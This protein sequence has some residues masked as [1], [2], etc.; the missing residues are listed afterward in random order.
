LKKNKTVLENG[1]TIIGID[2]PGAKT[3]AIHIGFR[4]GSRTE[5]PEISGI[6]HFLEHMVFKGS[7]KRPTAA[8]IAKEV[9]R[10]G[11]QYNA[12]TGKE[13]TYYHIH[14]TPENFDLALDVV[15]D[16]ATQ[17]II[18]PK[19]FQKER[20]TIIE[21]IKMYEDNPSFS[22]F[23]KMEGTLFGP[24]TV[25]GRDIA[26]TEESVRGFTQ[27]QMIAYFKK[28]YVGNNCIAVVAGKLPDNYEENVSEYLEV[29][30]KGVRTNWEKPSYAEKKLDVIFKDTEQAHFGISFPAFSV[31]SQKRF[32]A[33]IIATVLGGYMSARLFTEIRE[34]RGWA[35]RVW[36][37][38]DAYSDA[39][40]LG[41]YG[42]IRKD[43]MKESVEI[44]KNETRDLFKSIT[45]EEIE[46][47][48]SNLKGSNT[49]RFDNPDSVAGF[50]LIN[51]LVSGKLE[52]PE[53]F[54]KGIEGVSKEEISNVAEE[55]FAP[56]SL[57]LTIIGP[58]KK[59]EEFD[60]I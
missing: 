49:L 14:T 29:L 16:M 3:V 28:T 36:A 38:C 4:T 44:V 54:I 13:Y 35:Y 55:V 12:A 39:G 50:V 8:D 9:D 52:T 46:R 7:P 37:F 19:E 31:Q 11:A 42:G 53:D 30:E 33:E 57:Y 32:A 10:I 47:A 5:T 2:I 24:E 26:G 41:I 48:K 25:M 22:I 18:D 56:G 21:E 43:K 27:E 20:G 40:Y 34:K 6:S 45:D 51:Y 23:G 59:P 17:P 15:G 1:A 58:F 60:N